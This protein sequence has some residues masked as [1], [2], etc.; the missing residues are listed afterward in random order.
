MSITGDADGPPFRLGVAISDIVTGMFAAQG[1]AMA[2]I[3]RERTGRGQQVDVGMLDSTAAL[4]TYQAAIYFATGSAPQRMGNRHPT[5]VPYEMFRASDGEFVVAVGNDELWRAFCRVASL[6]ALASD[7]RFATNSARVKHYGALKPLVAERLRTRSR[8]EWIGALKAAGVPCGSVRDVAQVL[9][10]PH[11][12]T[13]EMVREIEHAGLG[14]VRVLGTPVKLSHTPGTVRSAPPTLGQ[15]TE[16]I[17]RTD[18]GFSDA[19][20]AELRGGG[21]V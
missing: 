10:D 6:D 5:I 9:E 18:L 4:L 1:I 13:R 3:A 15:H 2:L 19:E 14:P 20:I 12:H 16:Q 7:P 21:V 8:G 11:L 17:L